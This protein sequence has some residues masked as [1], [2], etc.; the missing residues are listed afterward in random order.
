MPNQAVILLA[1]DR[2]DDVVLI[3][4]SLKNAF[5]NNPL[6]VVRDGEEAIEYMSGE[7]R[8]A[9]RAEFPLPALLLLD[10]KMPR[11]DG[12]EVLKWIRQQPG[13]STLPVVV[14]TSSDDMHDVNAAYT[15][16]A[17]S[18]LVKPTEF[19]DFK[20]MTMFLSNY[21][22]LLNKTPESNRPSHIRE[23]KK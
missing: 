7:G 22:L 11:K 3:R 17:N 16:G 5:I 6:Q 23:H 14:L 13:L 1:E 9:N 15:A 21:W 12:F 19:E 10:L 4:R 2:E 18:F 8:Y 20:E